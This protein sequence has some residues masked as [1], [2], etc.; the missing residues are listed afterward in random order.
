[1]EEDKDTTFVFEIVEVGSGSAVG[2]GSNVP[3]ELIEAIIE[4]LPAEKCEA[5]F[6]SGNE[7]DAEKLEVALVVVERVLLGWSERDF[8]G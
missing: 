6:A 5:V 8:V 2:G 1:M 3:V 7:V 4:L